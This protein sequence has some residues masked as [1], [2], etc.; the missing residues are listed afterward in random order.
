MEAI[1]ELNGFSQATRL[2]LSL[3]RPI[4]TPTVAIL[5]L[6]LLRHYL[7]MDALERLRA[8]IVEY[9]AAAV[10]GPTSRTPLVSILV[11]SDKIIQPSHRM[12]HVLFLMSDVLQISAHKA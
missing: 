8:N 6:D 4:Y 11:P 12:M 7:F 5:T 9:P 3:F 1:L 10:A 2:M